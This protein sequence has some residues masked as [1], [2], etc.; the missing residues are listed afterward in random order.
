MN[1]HDTTQQISSKIF[2]QFTMVDEERCCNLQVRFSQ[3]K[4]LQVFVK[5][6]VNILQSSP[7]IEFAG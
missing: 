7:E 2:L 5:Q 3:E 1:V 4:K 6:V